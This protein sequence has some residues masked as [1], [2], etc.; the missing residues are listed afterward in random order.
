MLN[1]ARLQTLKV[2]EDHVSDVLDEARKRL[3]KVTNN[4]DLYREVLRKLIL[5]AILQ[6][7]QISI[8]IYY[9]GIQIN[10]LSLH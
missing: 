2:R 6:V 1:Q 5:Q 8:I 3:V 7:R 10:K 9:V 4:P